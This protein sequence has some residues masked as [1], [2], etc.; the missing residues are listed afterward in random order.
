[1]LL[2]GF[3]EEGNMWD[4]VAKELSKNHRLII[5]DLPGFGN[6]PLTTASI[7]MEYYAD[8]IYALL[9][10]EKIRKCV[11]LGHSM[12][13]YITL[14]FAE[15]YSSMLSGFGLLNSHCFEDSAEKKANRKKSIDF[16]AKHGTKVFVKELTGAIFH[17]SFKKKNA[18]FIQ[19]FERQGL[20]YSVQSL[21]AA[22]KAMI[23]RQDKSEVLKNAKVPV[24][25]ISGKEDVTVPLELSLKQA[26]YAS[27]TDFHLFSN[28]KHMT[29]FEKRK[30]VLSVIQQFLE[31]L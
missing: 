22:T 3:V 10:K 26:A 21:I 28:S 16:I 29:V 15:K 27:I 8:E 14:Y 24:L 13:G 4:G 31:I 9:K 17:D 12:G 5:P 1:M 30:Q 11:M 7:S 18:K 19:Q 6:S 2:H 20:S 23:N 25:L